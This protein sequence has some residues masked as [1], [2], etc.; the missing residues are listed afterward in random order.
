MHSVF[1]R[2]T[3]DMEGRYFAELISEV[4]ATNEKLNVHTETGISIY[5]RQSS[6]WDYLGWWIQN[7]HVDSPNNRWVVQVPRL[8][9]VHKKKWRH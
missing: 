7:Y 3:N 4:F 6:D 5:G 1:L 2:R 9:H 8:Y